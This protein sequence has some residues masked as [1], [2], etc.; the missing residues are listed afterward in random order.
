[1]GGADESEGREEPAYES[2][3][4]RRAGE[5]EREIH[6]ARGREGV[7]KVVNVLSFWGISLS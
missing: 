6:K 4:T 5:R 7:G 2:Q 1:M 3:R